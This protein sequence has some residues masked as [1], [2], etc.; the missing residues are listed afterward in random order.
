MEQEQKVTQKQR[1]NAPQL[2]IIKAQETQS[3]I[4]FSCFEDD[5]LCGASGP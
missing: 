2:E 3:A 1:W 4:N 5:Y